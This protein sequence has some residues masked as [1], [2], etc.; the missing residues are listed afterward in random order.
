MPEL[1]RVVYPFWKKRTSSQLSLTSHR[2]RPF[3]LSEG[4]QPLYSNLL[5]SEQHFKDMLLRAGPGILHRTGC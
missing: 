1:Q 5:I 3:F 4:N 2:P